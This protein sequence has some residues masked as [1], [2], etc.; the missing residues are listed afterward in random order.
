MTLKYLPAISFCPEV[1]VVFL[2]FVSTDKKGEENLYDQ[3]ER[4]PLSPRRLPPNKGEGIPRA[5]FS[6]FYKF[7]DFSFNFG[8]NSV[9]NLGV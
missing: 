2:L 7:V 4:Y 8:F 5:F 3:P 9:L 1:H 6:L